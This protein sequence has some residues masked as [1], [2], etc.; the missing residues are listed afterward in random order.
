MRKLIVYALKHPLKWS[1]ENW[2]KGSKSMLIVD[3]SVPTSRPY[4]KTDKC[5]EITVKEIKRKK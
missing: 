4:D 1:E 5:Y 2:I 3:D